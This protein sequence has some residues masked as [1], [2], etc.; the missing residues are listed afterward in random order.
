MHARKRR[1]LADP[2]DRRHRDVRGERRGARA[3]ARRERFHHQAVQQRA[4]D[5][6][7]A[8]HHQPARDRL[9]R[10]RRAARQAHGA[11]QPRGVLWQ[12]RKPAGGARARAFRHDVLRH[13][14]LQGHQR[15]IRRGRGRPYPAARRQVHEGVLRRHRRH[16]QPHLGGQFRRALPGGRARDTNGRPDARGHVRAAEPAH[17][18]HL[19]RRQVCCERS[20]AFGKRG[21]R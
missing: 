20:V 17:G 1:A 14:Q 3:R 13:R 4:A 12:G 2:R 18:R 11:V 9:H 15:P 7:P 19:Q 21:V 5:A 10:Q 8:Q 16:R 6:L